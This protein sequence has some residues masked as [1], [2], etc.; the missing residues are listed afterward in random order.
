MFTQ[1]TVRVAIVLM[2]RAPLTGEEAKNVSDAIESLE[3][4]YERM[5]TANKLRDNNG[6][7]ARPDK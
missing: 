3:A 5:T 4:L 1:D 6:E 2:R 7:H